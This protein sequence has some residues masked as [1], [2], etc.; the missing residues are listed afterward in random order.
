MALSVTYAD[1]RTFRGIIGGLKRTRL[2]A[3][4]SQNA[5]AERL[6]FRGRAISEWETGVIEPTLEHLI[7]WS[8]ALNWRLVIVGP[9]GEQ[10][11]GLVKPW[12]GEPWEHFER[13]RLATPLK[14]RRL[15]LKLS[16]RQLGELVGVSTDSIQRWELLATRPRPL[17]H[18]VWAHK[19][20][21][22]LA[23]QDINP[24]R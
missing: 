7:Q 19:L 10:I 23:L 14:N 17:A 1:E 12:P 18:I 5:L 16:Q 3:G 11:N 21:Y 2:D 13:L 24:P 8:R 4:L 15:L 20:G 6:R 22:G 9:D